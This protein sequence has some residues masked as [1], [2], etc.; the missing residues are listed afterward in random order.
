ML[1]TPR[2][3]KP[4]R[5]CLIAADRQ[6]LETLVHRH[7]TAH[8]LV[9]RARIVLAAADGLNNAQIARALRVSLDTARLWRQRWLDTAPADD[10]APPPVAARLSDLPRSGAPVQFT[11]EQMCQLIALA[12]EVPEGSDRPI[13]HWSRREITAEALQ[14][15]IFDQ[16]S[17]RHAD[18]KPHLIRYWMTP[19]P[20]EPEEERQ[21]KI[22]D[23]CTLYQEARTRAAAGERTLSTDEL[24]GVQALER[25]YPGLPL[26]PGKVARREFE[27]LR[28]GTLTFI[29]NFDVAWGEVV[30]PSVG[31][32][33]TEADF[34]AHIQ[35]TVASDPTATKW[36]FAVD[37][38][39]IHQSA[40]LVRYVAQVS[41]IAEDL[42]V[43]GKH[44]IL[45]SMKSRAAFLSDP[46]HK[47]VFHYTPKHASWMNQVEIWLSILV[48]RPATHSEGDQPGT[49]HGGSN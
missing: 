8:Q 3:P 31:P 34:V 41:G 12:C 25:K 35:P 6:A 9:L 23:L 32:T 46:S 19:P 11:A 29:L 15:G 2:G 42:G 45:K 7:T 30:T 18:L 16:I 26:A 4:I 5:I 39:N 49:A 14:R 21:A 43:V 47:I 48:R 40:S 27:Y 10:A 13:S 33:R 38:L 44:G 17:D 37:N 24:T 36:R 20:T 22:E 28:H 1:F